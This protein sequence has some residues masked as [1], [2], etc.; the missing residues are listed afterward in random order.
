MFPA[1]LLKPKEIV[2]EDYGVHLA[3]IVLGGGGV[4]EIDNKESA[5]ALYRELQTNREVVF[6]ASFDGVTFHLYP[7]VRIKD[8]GTASFNLCWAMQGAMI[9]AIIVINYAAAVGEGPFQIII[10]A[11]VT[12][13][14]LEST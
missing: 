12:I 14:P 6:V 8:S 7:S 4:F 11:T 13:T 9:Q 1:M 2:L 3:P 10:N 5:Q